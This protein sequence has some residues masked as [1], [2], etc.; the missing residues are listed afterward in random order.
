[1]LKKGE[2][3][4]LVGVTQVDQL[5]AGGS[6]Q[7][8]VLV[9]GQGAQ[10]AEE[11]GAEVGVLGDVFELVQ[12][13]DGGQAGIGDGLEQV[14]QVEQVEVRPACG[15]PGFQAPVRAYR[16]SVPSCAARAPQ[17]R[18]GVMSVRPW[19]SM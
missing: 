14:F 15:L 6:H 16:S 5:A 12:Q 4:S 9:D 7:R 11:I 3:L 17:K 1:M 8:Q 18:C 10:A 2:P 13:Q 19:K